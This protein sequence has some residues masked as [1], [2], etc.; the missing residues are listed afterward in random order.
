MDRT[1]DPGGGIDDD[2]TLY[3]TE[4]IEL[5]AGDKVAVNCTRAEGTTAVYQRDPNRSAFIIEK[6]R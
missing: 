3:F 5:N 1:R 2:G 6:L 4:I